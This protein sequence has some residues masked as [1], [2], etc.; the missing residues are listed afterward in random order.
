MN[1]DEIFPGFHLFDSQKLEKKS[2]LNWKKYPVGFKLGKI[3]V[4]LTR[5]FKLENWKNLGNAY[6]KLELHTVHG[7]FIL[8]LEPL[9][10]GL[11]YY[12]C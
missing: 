5:Y 9:W 4:H 12:A 10:L 11:I 3:P 8:P 2:I 1:K 6:S 7:S